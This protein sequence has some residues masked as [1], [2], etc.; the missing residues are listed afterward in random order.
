MTVVLTTSQRLQH[1]ISLA[2]V[3]DAAYDAFEEML[4]VIRAHEDPASDLFA[5]FMMAAASAADGRDA[6]AFSSSLPP[7][8]RAGA[9]APSGEGGGRAGESTEDI[10]DA[11]AGL[12]RLLVARLGQARGW[13][14]HPDDC[15]AC[16]DALRCAHN[17]CGLLDRRG[18]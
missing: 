1:A 18:P 15:A 8:S 10:A 5:A 2:G 13:S 6:V 16:E 9:G 3:L 17:I 14:S 11:V 12:S 7:S 4:Q